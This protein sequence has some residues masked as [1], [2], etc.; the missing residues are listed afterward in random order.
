MRRSN[1]QQAVLRLR[2]ND[3]IALLKTLD[4]T[5]AALDEAFDAADQ[6]LIGGPYRSGQKKP[7]NV[8]TFYRLF[9]FRSNAPKFLGANARLDVDARHIKCIWTALKPLGFDVGSNAIF[10]APDTWQGFLDGLVDAARDWPCARPAHSQPGA[11]IEH[12]AWRFVERPITASLILERLETVGAM[13][14][15]GMPGIGKSVL[16]RQIAERARLSGQRVI[17]RDAGYWLKLGPSRSVMSGPTATRYIGLWAEILREIATL[18]GWGSGS[19]AKRAA[20]ASRIAVFCQRWSGEP[21]GL[22]EEENQFIDM[23]G[24]RPS[25]SALADAIITHSADF[26]NPVLVADIAELVRLVTGEALIVVDDVLRIDETRSTVQA[27]FGRS[28]DGRPSPLRLLVTSRLGSDSLSFLVGAEAA[29]PSAKLADSQDTV[30]AK[31]VVAAWAASGEDDLT[32]DEAALRIGRFRS[33]AI[34]AAA[35]VSA[36]IDAVIAQVGG[37]A[38]ALAGLASV[39]RY[40]GFRRGFWTGAFASIQARPADLLHL[41]VTRDAQGLIDEQHLDV[42]QAL[43]LAWSLLAD[44]DGDQEA[45]RDRFLDLAITLPNEPIDENVFVA[46]WKRIGRGPRGERLASEI[47]AKKS[48]L[49]RLEAASFV[50]STAG[51]AGKFALH[52]LHRIL[53]EQELAG[54]AG[55]ASRHRDLLSA[56][57]LIGS[58]GE[59]R[60]DEDKHFTVQEGRTLLWPDL[61]DLADELDIW[62]VGRHL[63]KSLPH[64]LLS[65]TSESPD[66]HLA[67]LVTTY[68]FLQ[69]RLDFVEDGR[70]VADEKGNVA[71]LMSA[72]DGST[73]GS[74]ARL[75]RALRRAGEAV[76]QDRRQLASQILAQVP[77]K[78]DRHF[79]RLRAGARRNAPYPALMPKFPFLA[80]DEANLICLRASPHGFGGAIWVD[81]KIDGKAVLTWS[82]RTIEWWNPETG[83]VGPQMDHGS[84]VERAVWFADALGAPAVLSW[85]WMRGAIRLW[86]GD[87]GALRTHIAFDGDVADPFLITDAPGGLAILGWSRVDA[88]RIHLWDARTGHER[89]R[90]RHGSQPSQ[91]TDEFAVNWIGTTEG[92]PGILS[93]STADNAIRLWDADKVR[94]RLKIAHDG[95]LGGAIW[96]RHA[97][98]SPAV[99][100]WSVGGTI[101]VWNPET[102]SIRMQMGPTGK[103]SPSGRRSY[104]MSGAR[105]IEAAPAKPVVLWWSNLDLA[106][107]VWDPATAEEVAQL[108]HDNDVFEAR[109]IADARAG[110]T[111]ISRAGKAAYVWDA[112]THQR[113]A[114]IDHDMTVL[115]MRWVSEGIDEPAIL[116]WSDDSTVR[117]SNARTG[118]EL[119]RMPHRGGVSGAHW[120][121]DVSGKPVILTWARYQDGAVCLWDPLAR[122]AAGTPN[123]P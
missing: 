90:L 26:R 39:W 55:L 18:P 1:D 70:N 98:G 94:E 8:S 40:G 69:A 48:P 87:T 5:E 97:F 32:A 37:H 85:S 27:L 25:P 42:L 71:C 76:A 80:D 23:V 56:F 53:I 116:T 22:E 101:R 36:A 43:R 3:L 54:L 50:R 78:V 115:G 64:H 113:R 51:V 15:V 67:N 111:I 28:R 44:G 17:E 81:R 9:G 34:D 61:G 96:I 72:L 99:L 68:R 103:A 47:A 30:F 24:A 109:W 89:L 58:D 120:V 118:A 102:A 83:E 106:L 73:S 110:P 79:D 14:I 59:F 100:S 92:G 4:F 105:W 104:L 108:P 112:E 123:A 6:T 12:P 45:T 88:R 19:Q 35:D 49:R 7:G 122:A 10:D 62:D 46:F 21:A 77:T 52:D 16:A 11:V 91:L 60:L 119:A 84:Q 121:P 38:L 66:D 33:S 82:G 86:N 57:G 13:A 107:R 117:L 31:A 93:W 20:F 2:I 65:A 29:A 75:R 95:S 74:I 41:Q 63:L 114:R